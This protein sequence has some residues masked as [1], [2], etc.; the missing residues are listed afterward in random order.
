MRTPPRIAVAGGGPVGVVAALCLARTGAGVDLI[1][2]APPD[3]GPQRGALGREA[4]TLALA[5][6]SMT[7]LEELGVRIREQALA[8]HGMEVW[9]AEGT[10]VIRFDAAEMD[11]AELGWIV[12]N[13]VLT[14]ALWRLLRDS[15]VCVHSGVGVEHIDVDADV[16]R[17]RLD[18]GRTLETALV[19]AAD[20]GRSRIRELA[21][22][23]TR[24]EDTGQMAIATVAEVERP[25]GDIAWQ[26][27]LPTGP[28]AFLPLPDTDGRHLVSVVWSLDRAA[29]EERLALEDIAFAAELERAFESRLGAV[30]TVDRRTAFPLVQRHAAR[31][32]GPR[33]ALVGD[34][35]HVLHPLAGQGV[36]LGLRDAA[37]LAEE[38]GRILRGPAAARLGDPALLARYERARRGENALMLAAMSGLRRLFGADDI[39]VRWLR[40]VGLRWVD[41]SGPLKRQFMSQALGRS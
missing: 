18:D 28:L 15:E 25:H 19:V 23:D 34:A 7:L 20:G 10:G 24:D 38:L 26:R 2:P 3:A 14:E 37:V 36:N 29:A 13:G 32:L 31:Y 27:F 21:G 17:L 5:P 6:A 11:A 9:D 4:R 33:L 39:G 12:E 30:R 35:A 22:I 1:E 40:N 16:A 8:Y 41:R